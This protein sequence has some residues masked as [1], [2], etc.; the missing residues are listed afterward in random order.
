MLVNVGNSQHL[1]NAS[2]A[3]GTAKK[4]CHLLRFTDKEH[5][6]VKSLAQRHTANCGDVG[7]EPRLTLS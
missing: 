7:L 3:Q 1:L 5:R 4:Y 2:L 6:E